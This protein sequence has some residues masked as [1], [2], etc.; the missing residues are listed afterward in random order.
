MDLD[1]FKQAN[2]SYG[3]DVGDKVLIKTASRLT[4]CVRSAD[5]VCRLGGD[6]FLIIILNSNSSDIALSIAEKII[7]SI[8]FPMP[9]DNTLSIQVGVSVGVAVAPEHGKSFEDLVKS[10]DEAMYEVKRQGKNGHGIKVGDTQINVK[11][12]SN[13]N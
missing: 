3:H 7:K 11:S 9:I 13:A 5:L 10:A 1:G 2:D 8:Q 12:L 6:E 4:A